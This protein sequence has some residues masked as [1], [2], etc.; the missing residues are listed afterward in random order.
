MIAIIAAFIMGLIL[1]SFLNVC[2]A[3]LP[4]GRSIVTPPSHCPRCR[5]SIKFYDNIPLIS[6]MILRRRCRN[7]GELISWRYPFV[8]L[9]NGLLYAWAVQEFWISG[10]AFLVM[11]LCS[12]LIAITFIDFD[13]QIIPDAI[14]LPGMLVGLALAPVFMT[15]FHS[16]LTSSCLMRVHTLQDFSIHCLVCCLVVAHC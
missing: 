5:H 10:E 7:C 14:T 9:I 16:I 1:G 2:I 4:R 3:R 11:A 8:E 6:F 12:S 15:P 13:H